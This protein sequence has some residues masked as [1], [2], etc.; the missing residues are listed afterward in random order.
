MTQINKSCATE[1]LEELEKF[2]ASNPKPRE[3]KRALALKMLTQG[4]KTETIPEILGVSAPFISKWKVQYAWYGIEALKVKYQ[5]SR[6]YLNPRDMAPLFA[7]GN[8]AEVIHWLQRKNQIHLSELEAYLEDHYGIK[9]KSKQSYYDLLKEAGISWKK[10]Q[11][12]IQNAM[13]SGWQK[14]SEEICNLLE[15]NRQEIESGELVVYLIDECHLLWGDIC[16]YGWGATK[17][18]LE[19]PMTNERD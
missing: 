9:F 15:A 1:A 16:G 18:R 17:E 6:G 5:G 8:R 3:L 11:K 7:E 12:K 19:I 14:G 10:T 4:M 13:K 2:I